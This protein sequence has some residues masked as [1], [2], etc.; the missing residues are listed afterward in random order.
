MSTI[1]GSEPL[2]YR[3]IGR[4]GLADLGKLELD[5][6]QVER[7]LGPLPDI[8]DAVRRGP[9]HSMIGIEVAGELIG[10]YVLHPDR[11]DR[12]CWWLGWFAIDRRQQG[13]GYGQAVMAAIMDRL[14][15]IEGCRRVRLL[16]APENAQ[17]LRLYRKAG[18]SDI[19]TWLPTGELIMEC[20]DMGRI[21]TE[22]GA[23]RIVIED[24]VLHCARTDSWGRG[25]R[26]A[27][28]IHG[29]IHGPPNTMHL[30]S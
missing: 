4:S 19:D 2:S 7:F 24:V 5:A 9:A 26:S 29:A 15:Q 30:H 16:V 21:A 17:A 18:F 27:A 11:R 3:R 23:D 6:S 10:F 28:R 8:M 1:R 25:V 12:S 20:C 14:R 13:R 22:E